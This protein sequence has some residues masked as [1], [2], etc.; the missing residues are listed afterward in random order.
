MEV[1]QPPQ[2]A[3][4]A[5]PEEEPSDGRSPL[6]R[7]RTAPKKPLSVT[8]L[9]SPAWC[10][11]QYWYTLTKYGRKP[12][13]AAMKKGSVVHQVLQDQVHRTVP[14][15]TTTREDAWGLRIWNVIHGL[16][17]LR[18]TGT[19]RELEVWGVLDGAI[20]VNGVID[21]LS[22]DCPDRVLDAEMQAEAAAKEAEAG[23]VQRTLDHYI[24]VAETNR[25]LGRD[26][27]GP[28]AA[29]PTRKVYI[30]DVKTRVS[31]HSLP[32][33]ASLRPTLM[34]LFI[35]HRLLS[36]LAS[37]KVDPDV[38][39]ARNRVDPSLPFT[40]AFIA[41]VGSLE[42]DYEV[43]DDDDVLDNDNDD[44]VDDDEYGKPTHGPARSLD[45]LL[46]HNSLRQLWG[47]LVES[48]RET[49]PHGRLSVG[50]V[51]KV[52][53]RRQTDGDVVGE[54][55]L[56]YDDTV[57]RLYLDEAMRWWKGERAAVGVPVEEAYKCRSCDFAD[58]CSWRNGKIEESIHR[59]RQRTRS[60]V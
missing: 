47:L 17:T 60:V 18:E 13:T 4:G 1:G 28:G 45:T 24:R 51:L 56:L 57:L 59:H 31:N 52:E 38:I 16:R 43:F 39:F 9:V 34:Q 55:T 42:E 58:T 30:T 10:E 49:F 12:R 41:Q 21:E 6:K 20:V 48:L 27:A 32:S 36:D 19:T 5:P 14:V 26:M 22:Y 44:N 25:E 33:S 15:Q 46:R 53:Y 54:R 7:F 40:D 8:D 23:G 29:R 2:Q 3:E 50:D 35:Y 37:G 11:L